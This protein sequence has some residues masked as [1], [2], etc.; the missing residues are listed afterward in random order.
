MIRTPRI[1]FA[2]ITLAT[3]LGAAGCSTIGQDIAQDAE[4]IGQRN[5]SPNTLT[6]VDAEGTWAVNSAGPVRQTTLSA[7]GQLSTLGGGVAARE[8]IIPVEGAPVLLRSDS[9][10]GLKIGKLNS[11]AT[12][13]TIAENVELS[14][15]TSAP[16]LAANDAL[17]ALTEYWTTRDAA[18]RDRDRAAIE[19]LR[20]SAPG[21]YNVLLRVFAPTP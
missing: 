2:A 8:L 7:D 10:I 21:L 13:K 4:T 15:M 1:R 11:P 16:T 12:G 14:T 20:D 9:D 3:L 6:Q 5:T 17:R 18:Q 19:A